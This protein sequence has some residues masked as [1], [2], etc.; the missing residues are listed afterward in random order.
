M[1]EEEHLVA[2]AAWTVRDPDG[3]DHRAVQQHQDRVTWVLTLCS[4]WQ[5]NNVAGLHVPVRTDRVPTCLECTMIEI[6]ELRE[7]R[8]VY[9]RLR[10]AEHD[11]YGHLFEAACR[12]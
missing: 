6:R 9:C 11:S 12:P 2:Q 1:T 8:C 5:T 7:P 3:V 4:W 10:K